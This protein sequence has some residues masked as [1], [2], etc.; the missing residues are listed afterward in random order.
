MNKQSHKIP[1][2]TESDRRLRGFL[3]TATS[4]M[5]GF[6][7]AVFAQFGTGATPDQ[8]H[9]HIDRY[10]ILWP[11]GWQFFTGLSENER[12]VAYAMSPDGA[13]MASLTQRQTWDERLWGLDRVGEANAFEAVQI[14]RKI[15]EIYWQTCYESNPVDCMSGL[16]ESKS[17]TMRNPSGLRAFC[18]RV[19]IGTARPA[20]LYAR[21]LPVSPMRMTHAAIVNLS[22]AS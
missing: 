11:Q 6:C 7:V 18:G 5:A 14:G 1:S 15:P 8:L 4:L 17:Y 13:G 2:D 10:K 19:M 16:D 9:E 21:S 20:P 12:I 3:L 22:C